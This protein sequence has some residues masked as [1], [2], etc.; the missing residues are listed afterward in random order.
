MVASAGLGLHTPRSSRCLWPLDHQESLPPGNQIPSSFVCC[1]DFSFQVPLQ[2][3]FVSLRG[4]EIGKEIGSVLFKSLN[5]QTYSNSLFTGRPAK[6]HTQCSIANTILITKGF[7]A[8]TNNVTQF[9]SNSPPC[10]CDSSHVLLPRK[11]PEENES[12]RF[13]DQEKFLNVPKM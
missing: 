8:R 6:I 5:I 9:Q 11:P 4:K 12:K 2:V 1:V 3:C 13:A 7:L 10:Y